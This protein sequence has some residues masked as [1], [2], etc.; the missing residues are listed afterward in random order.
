[1]FIIWQFPN[2]HS[3][4]HTK[5]D[6]VLWNSDKI[7][8]V[9]CC[10][11]V[12]FETDRGDIYGLQIR[13]RT[14]R[15]MVKQMDRALAVSAWRKRGVCTNFLRRSNLGC[16]LRFGNYLMLLYICCKFVYIGKF[17]QIYLIY[18]WEVFNLCT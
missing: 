5:N 7:F 16:G 17:I 1:M 18:I 8:Y 12:P 3:I 2:V 13:D 11:L 10:C 15:A 14:V 9:Y 4:R 6:Y